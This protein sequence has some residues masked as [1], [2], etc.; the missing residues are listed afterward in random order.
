MVMDKLCREFNCYT[1]VGGGIKD[2]DEVSGIR[3]HIHHADF[4]KMNNSPSNLIMID[5][6]L[7]DGHMNDFIQFGKRKGEKI[8][9]D[10]GEESGI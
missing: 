2:V 3:F 1:G 6:R 9:T 8:W 4:Y 7:H 5:A 10:Y